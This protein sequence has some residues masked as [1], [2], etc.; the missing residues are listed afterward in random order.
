MK[1][2]KDW[3]FIETPNSKGALIF[4]SVLRQLVIEYLVMSYLYSEINI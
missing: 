4:H 1:I 3:D 2:L